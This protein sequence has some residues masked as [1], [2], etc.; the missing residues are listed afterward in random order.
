MA[1]GDGQE[2]PTSSPLHAPGRRLDLAFAA[3]AAIPAGAFVSALAA[4]AGASPDPPETLRQRVTGVHWL[5]V[6]DHPLT[7]V[8]PADHL[9][10]HQAWLTAS[11]GPDRI[12][13][14]RIRTSKPLPTPPPAPGQP[15]AIADVRAGE[16]GWYDVSIIDLTGAIGFES[17]VVFLVPAADVAEVMA[18]ESYETPDQPMSWF[19]GTSSF[20][21]RLGPA[22]VIQ[23]GTLN[24]DEVVG[25]PLAELVGSA[26][27]DLAH[28]DD[29]A[30]AVHGWL[31]VVAGPDQQPPARLRI[32]VAEGGWRTF[33]ITSWNLVEMAGFDVV[34][35]DFRDVQDQVEAEEAREATARAHDRLVRVLDEVDDMVLVGSLDHGLIYLNAPASAA[36]GTEAL[37]TFLVDHLG[38][39]LT[40]FAADEIMPE[41]R[42]MRSWTG[43]VDVR[44][45][46]EVRT[47]QATVSPVA[48]AS[49]DDGIY[50]G[51]IMHD[52]TVERAYARELADQARRDPLTGLP[53]RLAL[54][55]QLDACRT[56]GPPDGIVS[57]CFI[58]L[59]NLKIVNDGLG[60]SV[61]DQ[62]LRAVGTQLLEHHA[63]A[64]SRFGGDEFVVVLEDV[65]ADQA[66]ATGATILSAIQRSH[67][68]GIA[69]RVTA[70]IGVAASR[71]DQLDPETIIRD[72]DAA[73][74]VAKRGGRAR[75]V[76][77]DE[78]MRA[79]AARRFHLETT[80]RTALDRDEL[81]I[82]IQPVVDLAS[83]RIS[84]FEALSRWSEARPIEFI[85]V[86]EESG[87]ISRL[88]WWALQR[89]LAGLG[90]VHA[91]GP[92]YA[93]VR[94]G[95]NV[96]GHQLLDPDFAR[97]VVQ[98]VHDLGLDPAHLI[99]ELT[100]SVL[101][102]PREEI[103][104]VLRD[105]RDAGI[106]LALDDFGS[107]YSSLG[108]L[109]R[110]P[111]DVLKLDTSY[112]QGLLNDPGTRIIAE[113]VVTMA[114]RL[115]LHVVAEG[116]ETGAQLEL[117]RD[118]GIEFAQGNLL[119]EPISVN[120]T[121]D[122][123]R[124]A[125]VTDGD[126]LAT[127]G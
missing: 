28:P 68:P 4:G 17:I 16:A 120:D 41:L 84:G 109:R 21:L 93:E 29:R 50:Y 83:G 53:N 30:A 105:L 63:G 127:D 126:L 78:H 19:R 60:H 49:A 13:Q 3:L 103:D 72:A 25:R 5:S 123:L 112:T 122:L 33:E 59:D 55:E 97:L 31:A 10:V 7:F 8:D 58:D 106:S 107:G 11:Q 14:A 9:R 61:G 57:V 42:E 87:L 98:E 66:E 76:Q 85:P 94:M 38:E 62:L 32:S 79:M 115:G 125:P 27:I 36:L 65:N 118:M 15:E 117:V 56:S 54:M 35:S 2:L 111:I 104:R 45:H 47:M 102:D 64:I 81:E 99:L 52:V 71:R 69:A 101:I 43:E 51:V 116:V 89:S 40:R 100:E 96:S 39:D 119:G 88:G 46:G 37:G 26:V 91:L 34:I 73:M 114:S 86:A 20:R 95:V 23:G 92:L 74:Y 113:G 121:L 70:S 44:V 6:D 67:V 75:V 77:F 1:A 80:L 90:L 18:D 110:Y 82:H 22:G 124:V 48:S 108:Y 24:V 12:G